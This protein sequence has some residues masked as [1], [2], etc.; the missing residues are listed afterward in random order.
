MHQ[1]IH[2]EPAVYPVLALLVL[3]VPMKWLVAAL[4]AGLFHELAH[5]AA[6]RLFGGKVTAMRIGIFGAKIDGEADGPLQ[7]F[8]SVLAGPACS[9]VLFFTCRIFP[10]FALC[11]FVQGLFNLLPIFPLDGGR[12]LRILLEVWFP[13]R[14]Q[15]IEK[16]I[17]PVFVFAAGIFPWILWQRSKS[18]IL[19]LLVSCVWMTGVFLRKKP[20]KQGINRIQ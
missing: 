17:G 7:S 11:A 4:T 1:L 3:C 2:I 15:G 20:C 9:L 10:R 6:I 5:I 16:G 12:L 8:L 19:P 14:A 18:G 13:Q